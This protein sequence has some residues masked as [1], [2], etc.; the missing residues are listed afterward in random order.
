MDL[1]LKQK[2]RYRKFKFL[3]LAFLLSFNL[4]ICLSPWVLAHEGTVQIT[5]QAEPKLASKRPQIALALGSGGLRSAACVGVLKV[6]EEEAIPIDYIVGTGM[7]AVVGGLY[8]AG[9]TPYHI[10]E[11]F[12][13]KKLM[14]AYL[15]IPLSLRL[16]IV[17]LSYSPRIIGIE[18]YDGLY[19]GK[20]FAHYLNKQ[21]PQTE[22]DIENLKVPFAATALDLLDGKIKLL[23]KGNLAC[24]LQASSAI[25]ALRKPVKLE[26]GLFTD[27]SV[28]VNIPVKEAKSLGADLVIAIDVD[29]SPALKAEADFHKIGSVTNRVL[30]LHFQR[31]DQNALTLADYVIRP[32]VDNIGLI[33]TKS[34]DASRAIAAGE[35][36]ARSAIPAIREIIDRFKR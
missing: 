10:E 12:T 30:S 26:N 18:P 11:Q 6:L 35:L 8:C 15:T 28:L 24:A 5:E 20:R 22:Q 29:Q 9:L 14:N 17:P 4:S 19:R 34:T 23:N 31:L 21:V 13:R 16:V 7:G 32:Q 3:P 27:G 1:D 25:P 33:S 36:A 2:A